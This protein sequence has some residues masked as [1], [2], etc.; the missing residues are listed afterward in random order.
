MQKR[1]WIAFGVLALFGLWTVAVCRVDVAPI[2]PDGSKV[3]FS[4]ING[5]F[6]R[7]T[8]VHM[9]L[10]TITDWLGLVPVAVCLAF[11]GVGMR[12]WISR[13]R[14]SRVDGDIL[15]LGGFYAVTMA[16]YALFEALTINYR[17][18]L[19]DGCLEASYPSSTTLLV[20]CVMPTVV[21][22]VRR[23]VCRRILRRWLIV[24][25]SLFTAF[26]VAARLLSGVH[27]LSDIV[28]GA[29]L[30]VGLVMLYDASA[31]CAKK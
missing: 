21:W 6:H 31:R 4:A 9:C 13:K 10:Y 1:F 27:W 29:L 12:Q 28:G 24:L 7:L 23:R 14:L 20:L 3:G 26:M 22:Q 11:A 8:G 15:I 2:G 19:I 25:L 16:L 5:W 18:I 17:P 30:S